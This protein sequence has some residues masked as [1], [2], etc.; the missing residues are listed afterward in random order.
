M[1]PGIYIYHHTRVFSIPFCGKTKI[2]LICI[3]KSI[4]SITPFWY[5]GKLRSWFLRLCSNLSI[6]SQNSTRRWV[7]ALLKQRTLK[8][9]NSNK[10]NKC[11]SRLLHYLKG[12]PYIVPNQRKLQVNTQVSARISLVIKLPLSFGWYLYPFK[13]IKDYSSSWLPTLLIY[14]REQTLVI[15]VITLLT[16]KTKLWETQKSLIKRKWWLYMGLRYRGDLKRVLTTS[17]CSS[18]SFLLSRSR[19]KMRRGG[20]V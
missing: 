12:Q 2:R 8:C 13:E 16:K 14:S 15:Y 5:C 18:I 17:S 10:A 20:K 6:L 11:H 1:S 7:W 4:T 9:A 3:T 19:L